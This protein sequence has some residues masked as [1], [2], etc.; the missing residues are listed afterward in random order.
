MKKA[1]FW[2]RKGKENVQCHLCP[3]NCVIAEDKTGY[4]G[5]RKNV[6]GTLYSLV[7]G[8]PCSINID[9]IEKKPIFMF[10]PGTQCLSVATV[11]CNMGCQ[12]CQNWEISHPEAVFG[13]ELSPEGVVKLAKDRGLPG[14]AYTY[15]E[16]TVAWEYWFDC[17]KLARK[18]KLYNVWVSNGYTGLEAV[19]KMG[20]YLD[21]INV[22]VKGGRKFYQ[23]LCG[24]ADPKPIF[25]ALIEY[26]K[27]KVWIEVTN[28]VVPGWNDKEE[29]VR[30]IAEWVEKNLGPETPL[31][32][33][34]FHPD[35]KLT[36]IQATPPGTLEKAAEAA[37]KA[38]LKYVY[39]GN[40]FGHRKE[41]TYCPRCGELIIQR[42]GFGIVSLKE[43]CPKCGEEIPIA[44]K[45][46]M[47]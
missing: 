5:V 24:V 40:V 20:R 3:R 7:Y 2:E 26:K 32:L 36:S 39:V 34:A 35:Y 1:V 14:I 37:E 4:C 15:T 38:G 6:K 29:Q 8:K 43:K 12:F 27:Q 13:R 45:V 47:K 22:D 30:E 31:H 41:S 9:P 17:M 19:R 28:L 46:W 23:K 44:G 25:D 16:P 33:S 18:E 42:S 21:A 11:G 10:A